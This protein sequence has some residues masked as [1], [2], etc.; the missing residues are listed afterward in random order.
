[1]EQIGLLQKEPL[2]FDQEVECLMDCA[3]SQ[4]WD[5]GELQA[6]RLAQELNLTPVNSP[7]T[8][9]LPRKEFCIAIL[10]EARRVQ[11][12]ELI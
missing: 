10:N 6:R 8:F 9:N 1:M 12:V 11:A 2:S 4:D 5:L 3:D 7:I